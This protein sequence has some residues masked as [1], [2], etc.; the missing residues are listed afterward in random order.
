VLDKG[1]QGLSSQ[2]V[3]VENIFESQFHIWQQALA[4]TGA[5]EKTEKTFWAGESGKHLARI[6]DKQKVI[7]ENC[8]QL[9]AALQKIAQMSL[10]E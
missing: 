7:V 2:L 9:L 3:T 1:L 8:E 6:S 5:D 4:R 10:A